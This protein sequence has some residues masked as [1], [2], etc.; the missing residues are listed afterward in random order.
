MTESIKPVPEGRRQFLNL[1]TTGSIA[2]A[3]IGALYPVVNY[4]IP[5]SSGGGGNGVT[6]RDKAGKDILVSELLATYPAGDRVLTQ[7]LSVTSGTPTYVVIDDN[8]QVANYGLNAVCPHLGCVVPWD[9][10]LNQFKCPCHGSG[11]NAEGG[12]IH[13]P[14]PHPLP[15]EKAEVKDG[16]IIFSPWTD[17]DFRKTDLWNDPN[18]WWV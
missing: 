15:L 18:P 9:I 8:K 7:G 6:A 14:S 2:G 1:L 13:G 12:L 17:K 5:P 10:G 3:A 16:K 11:Y 4:F